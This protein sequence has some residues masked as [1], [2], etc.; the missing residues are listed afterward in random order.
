[1]TR[2]GENTVVFHLTAPDPDF[3]Y[4]LALSTAAAVP[5]STPLKAHAPVPAT[6]PYEIAEIDDARGV[7][8]L[9]RNPSFHL[10]SAAAQPDGAPDEIVERYGY[11]GEGAV[12]AVENGTADV[13]S[14]GLDQTWP[15]AL[16][17][18]LR[19]RHS[20]RLYETPTLIPTAVWLNTRLAPFDDVRV[21]RAVSFAVDRDHL[22]ELAGGPDVAQVGCQMLPPN[23]DGY[24]PYCPYTI[25]PNAAGAYNGPDLARARRLVAASGTR[26]Q[27]VTVWFYDIPIGRRNSAYLVS[28][29]RSLG[30]RARRELI[31][32]DGRSTWSPERQAGVAGIG[33][34]YPSANSAL[35]PYFTCRSYTTDPDTNWNQA[36]L[37]N[38][39]IDAEIA[40]ASNLQITDP[41]AASR[42]WT[43]IDHEVT[44]LAPWIVIR[45]S[46][47]ADFVSR[48]VRNYTPCW[49]SYWDGTTGACL[50]QLWVR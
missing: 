30:Y 47:A 18:S 14:D 43:R 4:K 25:H 32:H 40:H 42:L 26:G 20:S 22:I 35:R 36:E 34:I 23:V 21:R 46:V 27:Q 5:A 7:I 13:T 12:R 15:P 50:D 11:T 44:D 24:R 38:R 28:V 6:G 41:A 2:P 9:V 8:R 33:A 3:L 10:W 1:V 19:K 17:S 16:T 31:P 48:R 29:L 37:C 49:Q 45:E 39:R